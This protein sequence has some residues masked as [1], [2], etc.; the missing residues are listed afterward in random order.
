[1]V[2]SPLE[3]ARD[4]V[5]SSTELPT[6]PEI[7]L[8]IVGKLNDE[9]VFIDDIIPLVLQDQVLTG[10]VLRLVNSALYSPLEPVSSVREAFIYLGLERLKEAIFTCAIIDLFKSGT[11]TFNRSTLWTHALGV[12]IIARAIATSVGGPDPSDAYV[13][14]LLHDVGEVFFSYYLKD[15]FVRVS[16]TVAADNTTFL[17][18]EYHQFGTSHCEVGYFIGERWRFDPPVTNAILFHHSPESAPPEHAAMVAIVA[19]ANLYATLRR[20]G[21]GNPRPTRDDL[22]S[23]GAWQTLQQ[24]LPDAVV[25]PQAIINELDSSITKIQSAIDATFL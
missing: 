24:A 25:S 8:R 14:G 19:I 11:G 20:L 23:F 9:D 6:I 12:A 7:V 17:D 1:M 18:E 13:A 2:P 3:S 22:Y 15:D 5:S 10:R 16:N 21:Y 4:L